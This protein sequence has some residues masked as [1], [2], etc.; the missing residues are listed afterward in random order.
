MNSI[1]FR[2]GGAYFFSYWKKEQNL[3]WCHSAWISLLL[4]T[5]GTKKYKDVDLINEDSYL[6]LDLVYL[7]LNAE[8]RLSDFMSDSQFTK[9][10]EKDKSMVREFYKEAVAQI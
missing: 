1:A 2:E 10:S 8:S 9:S 3:Y 5:L 4:P 6:K 7:G